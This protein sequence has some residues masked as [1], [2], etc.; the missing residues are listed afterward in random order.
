VHRELRLRN[1][2]AAASLAEGLEE[3]LTLHPL[4][5]FPEVGRSFRTTNILESVMARIEAKTARMDRCRT[6][7]QKLRWTAAALLTIEAQFRRVKGWPQFG[8]LERALRASISGSQRAPR[9]RPV[10]GT[11][12]MSTRLG[13]RP[14]Q[15]RRGA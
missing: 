5:V 3:T 14:C 15:T 11:A 2:S 1:A 7:D 10:T 6:S 12:R 8:L 9:E 13:I 4:G